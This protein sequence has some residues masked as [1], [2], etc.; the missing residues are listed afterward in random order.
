MEKKVSLA[1]L[2]KSY[3]K[4]GFDSK[5]RRM[6]WWNIYVTDDKTRG[7]GIS[8]TNAALLLPNSTY[9]SSS[10]FP[11]TLLA[12]LLRALCTLIKR[13]HRLIRTA[14]LQL[15]PIR[16]IIPTLLIRTLHCTQTH[17]LARI[18]RNK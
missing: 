12:P 9:A 10:S 8:K 4:G 16:L 2:I 15:I 7:R 17:T 3:T 6:A 13:R 14:N 11:G 5:T 18:P 1:G